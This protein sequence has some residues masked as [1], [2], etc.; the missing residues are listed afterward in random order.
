[1]ILFDKGGRSLFNLDVSTAFASGG[2]GSIC[3][4]P[5]KPTKAIKV[6][7]KERDLS[8]EGSLMELNKLPT[9][10]IKPEEIYYTKSGKILGFSM[11]YV[12][13]SKYVILARVLL[14]YLATRKAS[15]TYVVVLDFLPQK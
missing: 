1:M 12:D 6:Y 15:L 11:Q 14:V 13:M 3:E 5:T 7:H 4:H 8:L 10:F 9:N 2:E